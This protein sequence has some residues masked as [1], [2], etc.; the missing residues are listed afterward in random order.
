MSQHCDQNP[1][2][3]ADS[4]V[5]GIVRLS[6]PSTNLPYT[7]YILNYAFGRHELTPMPDLDTKDEYTGVSVRVT[8]MGER[9]EVARRSKRLAESLGQGLQ[10]A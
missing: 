8:V 6:T 1:P 10:V 2:V 4:T 9:G 3:H 5:K 7:T